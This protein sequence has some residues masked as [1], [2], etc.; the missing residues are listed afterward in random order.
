MHLRTFCNYKYYTKN[1]SFFSIIKQLV[2]MRNDSNNLY[3]P[4][5]SIGQSYPFL[6]TESRDYLCPADHNHKLKSIQLLRNHVLSC[7][8]LSGREFFYCRFANEHMYFS[9]ED[10]DKH[11]YE[12]PEND[13]P[14]QF[15]KNFEKMKKEME[16]KIKILFIKAL[17]PLENAINRL[18][19]KANNYSE[20]GQT[21]KSIH[22]YYKNLNKINN[23]KKDK[24]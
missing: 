20:Q 18:M 5:G 3:Y 8:S 7:K 2:W 22:Y 6:Q 11:E 23:E 16:K 17:K 21:E 24:Q 14:G 19:E 10:R 4:L 1:R 13:H 15:A 12:C 9:R